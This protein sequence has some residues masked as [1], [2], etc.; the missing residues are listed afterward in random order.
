MRRSFVI[1]LA[2]LVTAAAASAEMTVEFA[3][4]LWGLR[5]IS[6]QN[7]GTANA[8][9]KARLSAPDAQEY[10][11]RDPGG[12]TIEP[13]GPTTGKITKKECVK[14]L[15]ATEGK[16]THIFKANCPKRMI[17]DG[18]GWYQQL[19]PNAD[20]EMVWQDVRTGEVLAEGGASNHLAHNDQLQMLCP[21][22]KVN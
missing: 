16:K 4:K 20:G 3:Y 10:C 9:L 8:V 15:L 6:L 13:G 19:P 18:S 5:V 17:W 12:E 2:L 1:A 11:D 7:P 21:G 14:R 22:A